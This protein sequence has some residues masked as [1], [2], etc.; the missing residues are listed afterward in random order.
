MA[1]VGCPG[2]NSADQSPVP[3]SSA[4]ALIGPDTRDVTAGVE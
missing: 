3:S 1:F 4:R 2:V